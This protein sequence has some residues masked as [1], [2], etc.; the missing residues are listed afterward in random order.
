[1]EKNDVNKNKELK[2]SKK[3]EKC[4]CVPF[5]KIKEISNNFEL[6]EYVRTLLINEQ[7]KK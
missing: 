5:S 7:N 2:N 3:V 4:V 6:G 1:M